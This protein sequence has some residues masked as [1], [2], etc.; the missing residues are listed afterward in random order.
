MLFSAIVRSRTELITSIG[1]EPDGG[2]SVSCDCIATDEEGLQR[3]GT[4]AEDQ[5]NV[6][7]IISELLFVFFHCLS[8]VCM[9]TVCEL[10][11]VAMLCRKLIPLV[12][13]GQY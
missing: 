7:Q 6:I 1:P 4:P 11:L 9:I 2:D 3:S 8:T 12:L 13:L 5:Q 10:S